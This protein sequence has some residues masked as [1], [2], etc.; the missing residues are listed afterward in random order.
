MNDALMLLSMPHEAALKLMMQDT[1]LP[2][3]SVN[4]LTTANPTFGPGTRSEVGVFI[5]PETYN[6]P[7][8]PYR[9]QTTFVYNRMDFAD[10]FNG[11]N[12]IFKRSGTFNLAAIVRKLNG[13]FDISIE[14]NDFIDM[15]IT[16]DRLTQVVQ[17]RASPLSARW[18]GTVDIEIVDKN[19]PPNPVF[20]DNQGR[21]Y[22]DRTERYY[23]QG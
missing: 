22:V 6:D 10:F 8:W 19:A 15:P 18:M 4:S 1:M 13:I 14:P 2:G 23:I 21:N 3:L 11:V 9:G 17:L 5:S 7:V 20:T 16:V 12:L